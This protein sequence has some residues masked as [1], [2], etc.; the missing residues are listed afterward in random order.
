MRH[1]PAFF[2]ALIFTISII[3]LGISCKKEPAPPAAPSGFEKSFSIKL[4]N[5]LEIS[6]PNQAVVIPVADNTCSRQDII[7]NSGAGGEVIYSPGIEKL[8]KETATVDKNKG[9]VATWGE[10]APGEVGLAAR[11]LAP[12]KIEIQAQ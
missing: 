1:R 7:I 2:C 10:G 12:V 4:T 6:L 3:L 11:L 8:P 9:Y 5:P